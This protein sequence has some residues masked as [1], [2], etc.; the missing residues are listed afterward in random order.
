MLSF[1]ICVCGVYP[2]LQYTGMSEAGECL[3]PRA[4]SLGELS[5]HG[6]DELQGGIWAEGSH[7]LPGLHAGVNAGPA[8]SAVG[9]GERERDDTHG[10]S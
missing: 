10:H 6:S 9:E 7:Q 5:M 3:V 2:P 4:A 8:V 1:C